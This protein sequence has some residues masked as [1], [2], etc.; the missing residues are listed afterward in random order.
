LQAAKLELEK[1]QL[2][3]ALEKKIAVRP[4]KDQLVEQGVLE[5]GE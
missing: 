5:K 3:D 4:E 1:E 2:H